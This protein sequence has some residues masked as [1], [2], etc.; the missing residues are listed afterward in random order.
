[1]KKNILII[2][3]LFSGVE[4]SAQKPFTYQ[5][6][7]YTT[8]TQIISQINRYKFVGSGVLKNAMSIH[9]SWDNRT[10]FKQAVD[11]YT[12]AVLIND[13][14]FILG[15]MK[16]ILGWGFQATLFNDSCIITSFARSDGD[17]YKYKTSDKKAVS[18]VA[19][20]STTQTLKLTK[21]PRF[22]PG[23]SLSGVV[24]LESKPF[25]YYINK[26]THFAT[27]KLRAYFKTGPL[28]PKVDPVH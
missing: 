10:M 22:K 23:E 19:L 6:I 17:I 11:C 13:T 14:I 5:P 20:A 8:D 27:I 21:N 1:M 4:S 24:Q 9:V 12:H 28:R 25:Y 26:A 15:Y 7:K 16:G 18:N 3:L 2:L